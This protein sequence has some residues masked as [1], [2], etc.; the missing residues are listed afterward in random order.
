MLLVGFATYWV[1]SSILLR[2]PNI[3]PWARI[4]KNTKALPKFYFSGHRGGAGE[5][6]ENTLAAFDHAVR[7]GCNLL[8][9]DVHLTSDNKVVV[10]HDHDLQRVCGVNSR[11]TQ[12]AYSELPRLLSRVPK[13]PQW[14]DADDV[15]EWTATEAQERLGREIPLLETV[16]E[17]YPHVAINIDCKHHSPALVEQVAMLIKKYNREDRTIW[18]AGSGQTA[19][20]CNQSLPD[21]PLI[22]SAAG[23]LKTLLGYYLG[24]LPFLSIRYSHFEIP[25]ICGG[26]EQ[27]LQREMATKAQAQTRW[28]AMLASL[29]I[30]ARKVLRNRTMWTHLQQRGV[31]VIAWVLNEEDEYRIAIEAGV[32]GIMTDYPERLAK[33]LQKEYPE[34]W[35]SIQQDAKKQ[36]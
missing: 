33:F 18:G 7:L 35:Q 23:C 10:F 28:G 27:R 29:L 36:A 22:F 24:L 13:P 25:L 20:L 34:L 15:V 30:G 6:P 19:T 21:T 3:L 4:K 31:K 5:R 2:F 1:L 12:L 17:R 14:H 8:E 11:I 32:D 16:F 26:W 9:L